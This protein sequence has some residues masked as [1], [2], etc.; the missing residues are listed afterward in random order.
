MKLSQCDLKEGFKAKKAT[1][2]PKKATSQKA[3]QT[4]TTKRIINGA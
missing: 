4:K 2:Q 1:S 3:Y